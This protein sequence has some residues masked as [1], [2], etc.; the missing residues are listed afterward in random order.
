M[1]PSMNEHVLQLKVLDA[2]FG[3]EW[4]DYARRTPRWIL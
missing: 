1:P 3:A 4:T 2:R